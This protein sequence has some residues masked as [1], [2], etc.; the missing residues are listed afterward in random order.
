MANDYNDQ[1][2]EL[3]HVKLWQPSA[4]FDEKI[5]IIWNAVEAC[6]VPW[7]NGRHSWVNIKNRTRV[8]IPI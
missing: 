3:A 1:K 6:I 4:N 5:W 7:L 2:L 8:N